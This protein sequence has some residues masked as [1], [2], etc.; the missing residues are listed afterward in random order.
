M[1]NVYNV[2]H[3]ILSGQGGSSLECQFKGM[4]AFRRTGEPQ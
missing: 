1:Y 4:T 2:P 3:P